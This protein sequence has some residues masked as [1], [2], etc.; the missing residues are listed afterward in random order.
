MP[1]LTLL[2]MAQLVLAI[3][4]LA[5]LGQAVLHVLAGPGRQ[6]NV[7]YQL[8]RLLSRPF[9]ASV[10]LLTPRQ[11]PDAQVPWLTF[12][13]LLLLSFTVFVERGFLLCEQ[14]GY[15]GCRG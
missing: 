11:L 13:L 10:R 2:N 3:A 14:L 5:L 8:L 15:T 12:L 6:A 1:L 7:F 9:T 4:L